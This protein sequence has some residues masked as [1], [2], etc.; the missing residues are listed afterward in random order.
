MTAYLSDS[1]QLKDVE[2]NFQGV[3]FGLVWYTRMLANREKDSAF[4]PMSNQT[5]YI[6]IIQLQA[7]QYTADLEKLGND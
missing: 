2:E 6:E 3:V 4:C 7:K 1:G 5:A